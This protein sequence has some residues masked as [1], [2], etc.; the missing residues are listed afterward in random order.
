MRYAWTAIACIAL[1]APVQART[2]ECA[3]VD[4]AVVKAQ[5]DRFNQG[6]ASKNPDRMTALF[7]PRAVLLPTLS[8]QE[9]TTPAGIRD[10][11]VHFLEKSPVGHIDTSTV[12]I[13]CNMAARMGN[14]SFTLTDA[15]THKKNIA[16]ARYTFIYSYEHGQ[17]MIAHLHSSL[18]PTAH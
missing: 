14:W 12:R 6:L 7:A 13:G 5:F 17:W 2:M 15:A 1:T 18:M 10:Y 9:R 11:F 3:P 8:D 16:H 4:D